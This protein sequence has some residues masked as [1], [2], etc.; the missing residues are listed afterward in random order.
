MKKSTLILLMALLCL[1]F[2]FPALAA[3]TDGEEPFY[4]VS[5]FANCMVDWEELSEYAKLVSEKYGIDVVFV[6][7]ADTGGNDAKFMAQNHY[8]AGIEAG[9][10]SGNGIVLYVDLDTSTW[11]MHLVGNAQGVFTDENIQSAWSA[12]D[13]NPSYSGGV[14][15]YITT[16]A[17]QLENNGTQPIPE[18]RQLERLVD[19]ADLLNDSEERLILAK[20]NE[21]SEK[22]EC[23]VAIITTPSLAGKSSQAFADDFYDYNGYGYGEGDDGILFLICP[24]ERDWAISTYGFGITAFT[25]AGQERLMSYVLTPLRDDLYFDAFLEFAEQCDAYLAQ[26]RTDAPYDVNNLPRRSLER[27]M[28]NVIIGLIF[29]M[30]VA[31]IVVSV[32]KSSLKSVAKQARADSYMR[33]GSLNVNENREIFLY[34]NV[35]KTAKQ[36][37]SSSSGGGGSSTHSSSSGRSHG[38]SSGKY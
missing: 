24:A 31:F 6:I 5:D 11:Y 26:S 3:E 32:M 25:D 19:D 27:P 2:A 16:V 37:S 38:G 10:Y 29:G 23:D 12:Y 28:T 9:Y 18:G 1:C 7:S 30:I 33:A 35:T 8:T 14:K 4:Y 21:I 15:D 34:S 20:L 17:M 13:N 22:Q 36:S